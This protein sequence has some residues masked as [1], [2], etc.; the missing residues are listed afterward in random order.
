MT[1]LI[2]AGIP[3]IAAIVERVRV[4]DAFRLRTATARFWL[5]AILLGLSVG[6]LVFELTVLGLMWEITSISPQ[7]KEA[8]AKK[9]AELNALPIGLVIAALAV[10]PAVAE[11]V[12]FRGY[13]LQA[14]EHR[15]GATASILATATAFALFH[16]FGVSG[17]TI[18]RFLP[19]LLLGAVLG[20]V[21]RNSGSVWPGV[22][23]HALNNAVLLLVARHK[24]TLVAQNILTSDSEHVPA[25]WLGA[26]AIMT[27]VGLALVVFRSARQETAH[28]VGKSN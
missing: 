14:L 17:L 8:I 26:A 4:P 20:L 16:T 13:L 15:W 21:A 10:V 24:E 9:A 7:L 23:L 5:A 6:L 28:D 12:F 19:S 11:E 22:I 27:L 18:E 3:L 25:I 2:F 1:A